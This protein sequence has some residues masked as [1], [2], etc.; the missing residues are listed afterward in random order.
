MKTFKEVLR[1]ENQELEVKIASYAK[2]LQAEGYTA[3]GAKNQAERTIYSQFNKE[4]LENGREIEED[5]AVEA[6]Q[7]AIDKITESATQVEETFIIN[8]NKVSIFTSD[9][10][11]ASFSM[12]DEF[13]W[14]GEFNEFAKNAG[15]K[16]FDILVAEG[17]LFDAGLCE[18]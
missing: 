2:E 7:W 5:V 15:Q 9:F 12:N 6:F 11:K 3:K 13:F 4:I 17:L 16:A 1:K 10:K 14:E 18:F 8:E